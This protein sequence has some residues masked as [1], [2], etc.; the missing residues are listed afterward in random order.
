[1]T[2]T[3]LF[4]AAA[5]LILARFALL[6][7]L[8]LV[9]DRHPVREAVSDYG[10]GPTRRLFGLMGV[11]AAASWFLLAAAT[12]CGW[13]QWEDRATATA[14]LAAM[15]LV[16]VLIPL[17]PT[18]LEGERLT[19]RGAVHYGLAIAQFGL[20]YNLSGNVA[21]LLGGPLLGTLHV[22]SAVSLVGLC[23]CLVPA[24]RRYF[25]AFERVF[26]VAIGCSYLVYAVASALHGA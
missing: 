9:S 18:D 15:G 21:R 26:I 4:A 20:A 2:S 6:A 24:L 19:A 3:I 12:W 7:R 17:V 14:T 8:H 10:V 5:P 11:T 23:V 1:M 22:I 13:P 16:T 25:G